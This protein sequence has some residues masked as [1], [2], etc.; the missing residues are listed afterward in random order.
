M[1]DEI[2]K[3][4]CESYSY[5][6]ILTEGLFDTI[7]LLFAKRH[8]DIPISNSL[9][10]RLRILSAGIK[11]D[12]QYITIK[13]IDY[14]NL[15]KRIDNIYDEKAFQ[16]ILT[17]EYTKSS[18]QKFNE[19]KIRK[20]QMKIKDLRIPLFFA[21]EISVLFSDLYD[22]YGVGYYKKV[23]IDIAEKT[24]VSSV[25]GNKYRKIPVDMS[26]VSEEIVYKLKPYQEEFLE[27]YPTVKERY[28]LDGYLL[29]FDQGLGKT[30]TSI[31]LAVMLRKERV[32][33]V[34]PN[35]LKEN[36][37]Y[38]IKEYFYRYKDDFDTWRN[39]V[40]V[41]GNPKYKFNEDKTRF[42]IV[43]MENVKSVYPYI[44]KSTEDN[45]IIIDEMH[46]FRNVDSKRTSELIELKRRMDCK[47]VIPMSGTPIKA[48]PNEIVP[49]LMCIDP[50]FND[51]CAKIYN[52]A[53]TVNSDTVKNVVKARFGM[54]MH[55]DMK[56]DVL[57][58]P[59]KHIQDLK[60]E[61]RNS[62][63]YLNANVGEAV[64]KRYHEIYDELSKTQGDYKTKYFEYVKKYMSCDN[65]KLQA[66][67]DLIKI[68][69]ESGYDI[70]GIHELDLDL[71]KNFDKMYVIPNITN[72]KELE[73][74]KLCS[75]RYLRLR[76]SCMGKAIGE[77]IPMRR[78]NMFIQIY[79]DNKDLI[80]KMI[81]R[82]EKK[83]V[84]F[85]PLLEVVNFISKD[86]KESGVENIKI[87]GE[88]KNRIDEINKFKN[89]D[90]IDVL[91]ATDKTLSTGVTIVEA[92][93]MFFFG[94]PWRSADYN[95]CCDRIYRIGQNVDVYIYNVLLMTKG[96][97]LSTKMN[98]I[99]NWS[100]GM[101]NSFVV[102]EN[103]SIE[104]SVKMFD[105]NLFDRCLEQIMYEGFFSNI[106]NKF[107]SRKS[108]KSL[109]PLTDEEIKKLESICKKLESK[110]KF[111]IN[112]TFKTLKQGSSIGIDRDTLDG[113]S[114]SIIKFDIYDVS[115]R[116]R[117]FGES[118]EGRSYFKAVDDLVRELNQYVPDGYNVET[119]GDWDTFSVYVVKK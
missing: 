75:T 60:L 40:Y 80:I 27:L 105:D 34:C 59:E 71:Y 7:K 9:S 17:K 91:I 73:D 43:N 92:N 67:M 97:N 102:E 57:T 46:N 44:G 2:F 100:E 47:D 51:E 42:V 93:Q 114:M 3:T 22:Y 101:F 85:S 117:D 28:H 36:W 13:G 65:D 63:L 18:I 96:G 82:A 31:A 95:Q 81:K 89:S 24:W 113:R 90:S 87:I 45:M 104:R 118:S 29:S 106:A 78:K 88:T 38:E 116:P 83:T 41:V 20:A 10:E 76:A 8:D 70:V 25:Y 58:L 5:E 86:L 112:T 23:S 61:C 115:D 56:S 55:R 103:Y 35:S 39:E 119:D 72:H 64:G 33:I 48:A 99:L 16:R 37:S 77:I 14:N 19:K 94:T 1:F 84:I 111:L 66:Y 53:F 11:Y 68:L 79:K 98:K 74:F 21:L 50:M 6:D 107:K 26:P 109:E 52:K 30:L 12:D 69:D 4:L 32:V 54:I 108:D 62:D 49:T 15:Y 110:S